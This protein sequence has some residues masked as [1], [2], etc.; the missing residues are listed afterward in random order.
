MEPCDVLGGALGVGPVLARSEGGCPLG[1]RDPGGSLCGTDVNN[2]WI[3]LF[4]GPMAHLGSPAGDTLDVL[5]REPGAWA[6]TGRFES[7]THC[8]CRH[9]PMSHSLWG[10]LGPADSVPRLLG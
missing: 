1:P 2:P 5:C 7:K 4:D 9:C 3:V 10:Q 8:C 6:A